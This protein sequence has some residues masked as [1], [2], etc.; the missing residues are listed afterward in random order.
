MKTGDT[1]RSQILGGAPASPARRTIS[2][3]TA[4]SNDRSAPPQARQRR[5]ML[6]GARTT[7]SAQ[8][9]GFGST[10]R[11]GMTTVELPR[12]RHNENGE[13]TSPV[14]RDL[15]KTSTATF[16]GHFA[17]QVTTGTPTVPGLSAAA[18]VSDMAMRSPEAFDLY[19]QSLFGAL[20]Q[21][22][23]H[24]LHT[25]LHAHPYLVPD[26]P[27]KQVVLLAEALW[28]ACDGDAQQAAS[29]L[30]ALPGLDLRQ[31][32]TGT[33]GSAEE[34]AAWRA[35]MALTESPDGFETFLHLKGLA[36]HRQLNGEL[37]H[38]QAFA[39][40]PANGF[41][42][43]NTVACETLLWRITL[44]AMTQVAHEPPSSSPTLAA[45][46]LRHVDQLVLV[47][48]DIR[49]AMHPDERMRIDALIHATGGECAYSD[50]RAYIDG[51]T[52][53][54][55]VRKAG[56]WIK[57]YSQ[58]LQLCEKADKRTAWNWAGPLRNAAIGSSPLYS[59]LKMGDGGFSLKHSGQE[60]HAIHAELVMS[61]C[62][63][64]CMQLDLN[65]S[66]PGAVGQPGQLLERVALT[67]L[68][69]CAAALIDPAASAAAKPRFL[70]DI[71]AAWLRSD[72]GRTHLDT[73]CEQAI[74]KLEALGSDVSPDTIRQALLDA[75]RHLTP[76]GLAAAS[77]AL[78]V[79]R[80]D[81]VSA[82]ERQ[83][84]LDILNG[85]HKFISVAS[86]QSLGDHVHGRLT[87]LAEMEHG[88]IHPRSGT[89]EEVSGYF[90]R[91]MRWHQDNSLSADDGVRGGIDNLLIPVPLPGGGFMNIKPTLVGERSASFGINVDNDGT[92]LNIGV[93]KGVNGAL[94]VTAGYGWEFFDKGLK[95]GVFGDAAI[96]GN[97]R[98]KRGVTLLMRRDFT[99]ADNAGTPAAKLVNDRYEG[100]DTGSHRAHSMAFFR[101]AAELA[102]NPR[103]LD[104]EAILAVRRDTT[105]EPQRA[106]LRRPAPDQ[107]D[108]FGAGR[109]TPGERKTIRAPGREQAL[110]E[111][112]GRE[113]MQAFYLDEGFR[114]SANRVAVSLSSR[115]EQAMDIAFGVR[116][117]AQ[118]GSAKL[119][120]TRENND[121]KR[122]ES[123][124]G[125]ATLSIVQGR[126]RLFDKSVRKDVGSGGFEQTVK[127]TSVSISSGASLSA[128]LPSPFGNK[129]VAKGKPSGAV[130]ASAQITWY[131]RQRS[132]MIRLHESADG[133]LD[134][135]NCYRGTNDTRFSDFRDRVQHHRA[136]L[137]ALV[138]GENK[139][140]E[141]L[142]EIRDRFP[143]GDVVRLI[144]WRLEQ[145]VAR[146]ADTLRAMRNAQ[147]ARLTL[148]EARVRSLGGAASRNLEVHEL[149]QHRETL[150]RTI[151]ALRQSIG[152]LDEKRAALLSAEQSWSPYGVGV[153][154]INQRE[155]QTGL[156]Y[157]AL[158]AGKKSVSGVRETDWSSS[159]ARE[160]TYRENQRTHIAQAETRLLEQLRED[161]GV[162][163]YRR[164]VDAMLRR[165]SSVAAG[166]ALL[167]FMHTAR[168]EKSLDDGNAMR[169]TVHTAM[170]A[171]GTTA[172][173][174]GWPGAA[175][176][177][178]AGDL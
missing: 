58:W 148:L 22:H 68:L 177:W 50:L 91:A 143:G 155:D 97:F 5:H 102:R 27:F 104:S 81:M 90:V 51:L 15:P 71:N 94:G 120:G 19:L 136:A 41:D 69:E 103:R 149:R 36:D 42:P 20:D 23:V 21:P 164:A 35:A 61:T 107:L 165:G 57:K 105:P 133:R 98:M 139:L 12:A 14:W 18:D 67:T 128:S 7:F 64:L 16:S 126:L 122:K 114:Y 55:A 4:V 170:A 37:P 60:M 88:N 115:K 146:A 84:R 135:F 2:A 172:A 161:G 13:R 110:K 33:G 176:A 121:G 39:S 101:F 75:C 77:A 93:G 65:L 83:G 127:G 85:D 141:M 73:M 169:A 38:G 125:N 129:D 175:L 9:L 10:S 79:I 86:L 132:N 24:A 173:S 119:P 28:L 109:L 3:R 31:R 49:A 11:R 96:S 167:D 152:H 29:T 43:A 82:A 89:I 131:E 144:R 32:P 92:R 53:D 153:N 154:E 124:Y 158:L 80:D 162:N 112:S 166:Q 178:L 30:Q 159:A 6:D 1:R 74:A 47:L 147:A 108:S 111:T 106:Q 95:A 52:T 134:A 8:A 174:I 168:L 17:Q 66:L 76:A 130:D 26:W 150:R 40:L 140:D 157:M 118:G 48:E 138:G 62:R 87:I 116:A 113:I 63:L 145:P 54:R 142:S 137:S 151:E 123:L 78:P 56:E 160:G 99:L 70:L 34:K 163:D 45:R 72:A 25:A 59:L 100:M 156:S 44:K 46:C 117:R 171:S